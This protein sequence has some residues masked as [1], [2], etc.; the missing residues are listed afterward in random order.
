MSAIDVVCRK[1]GEVLTLDGDDDAQLFQALK[2]TKKRIDKAKL[3]IGK[4]RRDHFMMVNQKKYEELLTNDDLSCADMCVWQFCIARSGFGNHVKCTAAVIAKDLKLSRQAVYR[5]IS[6]LV[7]A[8]ALRKAT[9][10]NGRRILII[11]DDFAIKGKRELVGTEEIV[12]NQR[13]TSTGNT[14]TSHEGGKR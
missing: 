1:T 6:K 11:N 3:N 9:D 2:Q 14:L 4:S 8:K 5:A 13:K 12:K 7:K 10:K